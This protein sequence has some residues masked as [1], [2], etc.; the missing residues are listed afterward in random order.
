M[1]FRIHTLPATRETPRSP[2]PVVILVAGGPSMG[3]VEAS[4]TRVV[5]GGPDVEI[6]LRVKP[7]TSGTSSLSISAPKLGGGEGGMGGG[8]DTFDFGPTR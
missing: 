3:S 5:V 6:L 1:L 4:V 8:E 7:S 2:R